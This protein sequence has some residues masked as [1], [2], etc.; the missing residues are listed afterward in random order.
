MGTFALYSA[1]CIGAWV[2]IRKVYPE[3]AGLDLEDVGEVLRD[4]WGVEESIRKAEER[5][6][7]LRRR[8]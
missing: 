7:R 8:F 3:T 5:R 4:G 6:E 1:V 2:A